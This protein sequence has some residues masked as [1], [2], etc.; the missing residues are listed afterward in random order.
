MKIAFLAPAGAMHRFHGSFGIGIHYAP[1]TLTT[2]A[3][4]VPAELQAQVAVYDE[5][6][7]PIPLD[8][9]ADLVCITMITGTASRAYAFAD[10]YRSRGATVVLGGVHASLL[11]QE[12]ARHADTVVTGF[13]EQT[14]PQL[15]R[16]FATGQ[17]KPRYHQN[18]DYTIVGRPT[19]R[20]DLLNKRRYITTNTVEV[21]RG[22]ALGCT[23]CAY[24]TAFGSAVHKRP[25]AEAIAEI[26]ALPGKHVVIPDINL[27]AGRRWTEEFFQAL[28]PL[29]KRWLGLVTS[30][31]GR[32]DKMIKLF[33]RSGCEGLLI[34]FE[35][36]NDDTQKLVRKRVNKV[37]GYPLLM[38]KLHDAGI[39][40]QG[41]FAFG[42]DGED[43]SVFERTVEMV[44]QT[45]M[46]L[47]RYSILTPFPKTRLYAQMEAEG[48][49]IERDWAM[50]DVEHVVF[51]PKQM[52]ADQLYEGIAWAW[53]Q[54]YSLSHIVKRLAPFDRAPLPSLVTN[55]FG[56]RGYAKKFDA[57][58]RERMVDNSDIPRVDV[59]IG[60][61]ASQLSLLPATA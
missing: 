43:T 38:Q 4:L 55:L 49:I 17:L 28:V 5:T 33:E 45:K 15:C 36:I 59:P 18:Y 37:G 41:C 7:G 22:C 48:R 24:P 32:D 12:A 50:Y 29:K 34:G 53:D 42:G 44:M 8:L 40:V 14:F 60:R 21:V 9:D 27:L 54:T 1:L 30:A 6:A 11:P 20:R 61:A 31:I 3:A 56:Y 25:V 35:S 16:D 2:L 19:P 57:F 52:T 46:D 51:Q 47:P 58:P 26:E 23:F 13:A 10:Y 39:A